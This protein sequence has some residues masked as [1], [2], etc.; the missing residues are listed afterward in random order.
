[1]LGATAIALQ[2]AL[3]CI[4]AKSS[5]AVIIG[6]GLV[7]G[8]LL[9]WVP[10]LYRWTRW[11]VRHVAALCLTFLAISCATGCGGCKVV[12]P[13]Y[14]GIRVNYYGSNKGVS[15]FPAV[16]GMQVY[17]PFTTAILEYPT[18]VQT[19]VWTKAVN[20]G[21]PA[22]E[23]ISFNTSEGLIITA[24]ISL[25]YQLEATKVPDFYVKFRSDDLRTFT[26]GFLHNVARDAFNETGSKYTAEQVY[27]E[28][29][30]ALLQEVRGRV[31]AAVSPF[32]VELQQLGFI[33]AP[34]LPE[35]VVTALNAK[36]TANQNAA[37]VQNEL[38]VAQAEAAKVVATSKGAADAMRVA[39]QGQADANALVSKSL[40]PELI[41]WNAIQRWNGVMPQVSN[42]TTPTVLFSPRQP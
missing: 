30:E 3:L 12:P 41:E 32:G 35:Q 6:A 38:A 26:H 1:M 9:A 19:A 27:G 28:H 21:S 13:G 40:T 18:Y 37:R 31:N 8:L 42:G 16:T 15:D 24:D 10:I 7:L 23:E 17:N 22:N 2:I 33:G 5:I 29:K 39:A 20:E 36:I 14:V 4:S 25:S 11:V 34:R